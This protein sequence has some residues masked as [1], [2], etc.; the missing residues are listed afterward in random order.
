MWDCEQLIGLRVAATGGEIGRLADLCF[1][2]QRWVITYF[3]V[4]CPSNQREL[5]VALGIDTVAEE[6]AETLSCAGEWPVAD[7]SSRS[8]AAGDL[9]AM[10][11]VGRGA[12]AGAAPFRRVEEV[13]GYRVVTRDGEVGS[14]D[15]FLIRETS[16]A[17]EYVIVETTVAGLKRR[18]VVLPSWI[19]SIDRTAC[20]VCLGVSTDLVL[21]SPEFADDVNEAYETWLVHHLAGSGAVGAQ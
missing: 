13:R 14:L 8:I 19:E 11:C 9:G 15:G 4:D 7:A 21:S 12:T 20:R 2:E 6:V 17:I 16:W 18:L 10:P 1:D 5:L 3:V